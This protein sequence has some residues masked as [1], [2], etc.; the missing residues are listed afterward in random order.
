MASVGNFNRWSIGIS[1]EWE[2]ERCNI[3]RQ[4]GRKCFRIDERPMYRIW[5]AYTPFTHIHSQHIYHF[6][7]FES[8]LSQSTVSLSY[9]SSDWLH[10]GK[11]LTSSSCCTFVP[12]YLGASV[13]I[14]RSRRYSARICI[15]PMNEREI[16]LHGVNLWHQLSCV[17]ITNQSVVF[18]LL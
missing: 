13:L 18:S 7:V 8:C 15:Y 6:S 1:K 10:S 11:T 4:N 2:S 12:C 16:T 17:L 5:M 14:S 9:Y 3:R